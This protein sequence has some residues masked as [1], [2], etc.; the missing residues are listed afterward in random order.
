M[1]V[2]LLMPSFVWRIGLVLSSS[3]CRRVV[4]RCLI[5]PGGCLREFRVQ[6]PVSGVPRRSDGDA[7][8]RST[9]SQLVQR[10]RVV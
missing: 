9:D 2:I 3:D 4:L 1:V 7:V 6:V 10:V 8:A 5:S